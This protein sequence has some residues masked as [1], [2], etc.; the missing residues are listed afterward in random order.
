MMIKQIFL[1]GG[2]L[3]AAVSCLAAK[4]DDIA[5]FA[6]ADTGEGAE[7]K[8]AEALPM[9][10][11]P[12][13]V[14]PRTALPETWR[15]RT[16]MTNFWPVIGASDL[17]VIRSEAKD[18]GGT[19]SVESGEM[20]FAIVGEKGEPIWT[21]GLMKVGETRRFSAAVST[22]PIFTFSTRGT[23][24]G[25]WTNLVYVRDKE[26][27]SRSTR[28]IDTMH[29]LATYRLEQIR[30]NRDWENPFVFERNR[31]ARHA[32]MMVYPTAEA[33]Q[34]AVSRGESPYF[35]SLDGLWR[36]CFVPSPDQSPTNFF[37]SAFDDSAWRLVTVPNTSEL[38]GFGTP[39][40][41]A[42]GYWWMVDPPFV[43]R[44]PTNDKWTVAREPNG[45]VCYRRA[46][47]VPTA[48]KERRVR[49]MFDGFGAAIYVWV[50]GRPV[51]YA[52]DGRPGAEFDVTDYV[53]S[54]ENTLAV[55]VLRL[56]DGCY[57]EDQ[58]YF[59][60]S[61]LFRSVYLWSTPARHLEDFFVT[62]RRETSAEPYDGGLWRLDVAARVPDGCRLETALYERDSFVVCGGTSLAVKA[63]RLWNAETPNLYRLVLTLRDEQGRTLE[64][65]PQ[66]VGF[67][68][69]ENR[70]ACIL[71]NGQPVKFN[72]VNRHEL[73]PETG[74]ALSDE[75]I[76]RDFKILK[77][78]N[79]N[80]IR[81]SHY[82]NGPRFYE[83]ANEYGFYV[84][85]EANFE[86][87][88]LSQHGWNGYCRRPGYHGVGGA[89]NPAVD[90]RF[91]AAAMDRET[92]MV[93]RDR[94]QPCVVMWSLGNEIFVISDFFTAAYDALKALDP[95]RPVMNQRNGKKDLEDAMYARPRR[96]LDY[97]CQKE[98]T[99]PFIP[100]EY[101][102]TEGNSYG[103]LIDYGRVF[104]SSDCLQG[105]FLWDFADQD[106]PQKRDP[107]TVKPGQPD[108]RW[109]YGGDFGDEPGHGTGCCNG[110][111]RADR[112][113]SPGV[114]E[115]KFIYQDAHIVAADPSSGSFTITNRA[116]FTSLDKYELEWTCEDDGRETA[117][118]SLGRLN[119]PPR[120]GATFSLPVPQVR[121]EARLRTW[122]FVWKAVEATRWCEKGF[123]LARDQ[124]VVKGS[125]RLVAALGSA[126]L[127]E[128]GDDVVVT[129]GEQ[130]WRLS[131]TSGS[132]FSWKVSGREM[133]KSPIEPCFWRAP[134]SKERSALRQVRHQWE[135]A[136][137]KRKVTSLACRVNG[138]ACEVDVGFS[139]PTAA[140][141]SASVRYRFDGR[142]S[143]DFTLRPKGLE[144]IMVSK[145]WMRPPE[146]VPPPIPRIGLT[147]R[148]GLEYDQVEWFGRGPHENYPG[149]TASAFFGRHTLKA[150][151]F[152]FPYAKPQESG[153]R[154]D[155]YEATVRNAA[156]GGLRIWASREPLHFNVLSYTAAELERRQHQAE[157][158]SC[159][160]WIVHVD[161]FQ[162]G[163]DGTGAGL[164]P[165][166]ELCA[167]GEYNFG[168]V[169]EVCR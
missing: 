40:F 72:G 168:F 38:I 51:G 101:E 106:F 12:S 77:Q 86:S 105:G 28:E 108:W 127:S 1:A 61:G 25:S 83:L 60:L 167:E 57:M 5:S 118:G 124:V 94:N 149:R 164:H 139:F 157:L 91:R 144:P 80:A 48:W 39:L 64:S 151:E 36:A 34:K 133:L 136:G 143:V 165:E 58:D 126:K 160:D 102:H 131:K 6:A 100:C 26:G 24:S 166:D 10:I 158:E 54:G 109:A 8:L 56:C 33:A 41:C 31:L 62:T 93:L 135:T 104:W 47:T 79:V 115:F 103:N 18:L 155:V 68:E 162:R 73:C 150:A 122:N 128:V 46:F 154:S 23:G 35:R 30:G 78:N 121:P 49:L 146:P 96:L 110:A 52:E 42:F 65:I 70:G 43:T 132:V 17:D 59:R 98:V 85:D 99:R 142:L 14:V 117:G 13:F 130:V 44:P 15:T 114:P 148:V 161:G 90:P 37:Q 169:M 112:T 66:T 81:L 11:D 19:V 9:R 71:V 120:G 153:N 152:L 89:R 21:S 107:K 88:G 45:T 137:E 69:V 32:S 27:W 63:P 141:T 125:N 163:V 140:E 119:V 74:Y 29:P 7:I 138:L 53:T 159:G 87:H 2:S 134:V 147:F 22:Y 67:R 116:F 84:L 3:L 123:E 75:Q 113:P 50:N 95:T 97:A 16:T 145:G 92:G 20:S 4:T 55:Q 76:E 129:S 156:G 111:F 82:P